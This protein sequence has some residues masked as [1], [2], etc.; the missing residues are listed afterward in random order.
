MTVFLMIVIFTLIL[1]EYEDRRHRKM[2]KDMWPKNTD[3]DREKFDSL[4]KDMEI[5]KFHSDQLDRRPSPFR[6]LIK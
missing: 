4:I 1:W 2:L 3:L 6:H 5:T